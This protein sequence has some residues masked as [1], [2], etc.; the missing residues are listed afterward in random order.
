MTLADDWLKISGAA[1]RGVTSEFDTAAQDF[2]RANMG[3][4]PT[5]YGG[6]TLD[7]IMKLYNNGIKGDAERALQTL[8]GLIA[9][10]KAGQTPTTPTTP[11]PEPI[12]PAKMNLARQRALDNAILNLRAQGIDPTPFLDEINAEFDKRAATASLEKDPYSVFSDDIADNV[13]KAKV[14]SQERQFMEQFDAQFGDAADRAALP[15][16]LLD[17]TINQI[18]SE[19]RGNAVQQLERGKARGIYNDVGYNAGM[20]SIDNAMGVGRSDLSSLSGSLIDKYL[21]DLN[22]IDDRAYS[23]YGASPI[24]SGTFSLDPYTQQRNDFI[25]RTAA[26]AG[27]DLRSALGGK[28]FFDFGKIGQASGTAQGA[29]NLRDADV[30]TALAERKRTNSL[31]RGLGS[32]GAF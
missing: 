23:A 21:G 15:T 14:A 22:K 12:D 31:S 26:N 28:N 18:L 2:I 20:A 30:A 29:L 10:N 5:T 24:G 4:I 1:G 16:S 13:V 3:L 32:Q 27:G 11:T 6:P 8:G 9:S 25:G 7:Q 17:D 19:Q